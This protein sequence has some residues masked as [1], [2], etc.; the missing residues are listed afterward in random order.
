MI[1]FLKYRPLYAALSMVIFA[2]FIGTWIYKYQKYGEAFEYSVDFTGGTQVLL[3]FSQPVQGTRVVDIL[4]KQGWH[5]ALARDFSPTEV[6]IR[7]KDFANDAKGLAERIKNRL[8]VELPGT[9]VLIQQLDSVGAGVGSSLRWK[10]IQAI[11][12]GLIIM[13]LY[14]WA[15]FWSLSYGVGVLVSL[16]HDAIVILAFFLLFNYE[17]SLNVI[18]AILAVLGYS[19]NDTIVIF[20]RI[21]EN[22]RHLRNE[23]IE[24]VVNISINE[25][26]RRTLL[27]SFATCLVVVALVVFGGPVL[28]TLSLALLVGMVFGTY[29][30]IAIA[31]PVMLMLYRDKHS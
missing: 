13:L 21:R 17:I 7:V 11:I 6:L 31:S 16:F 26:L 28:R 24:K 22:V 4:E 5:G 25:T 20:S 1:D 30:S 29:S 23:P 27:T 18:G 9:T 2:A 19:I 10:S 15:R 12:A 14:T 8:E 3:Q